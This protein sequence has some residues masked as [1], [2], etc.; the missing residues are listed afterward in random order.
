MHHFSVADTLQRSLNRDV[1]SADRILLQHGG[2]GLNARR[3]PH[4][5][6]LPAAE[7]AEQALYEYQPGSDRRKGDQEENQPFDKSEHEPGRLPRPAISFWHARRARLFINPLY[8]FFGWAAA[9][10]L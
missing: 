1:R 4:G 5:I 7:A 6:P 2:L 9:G 10:D 3:I 8:F